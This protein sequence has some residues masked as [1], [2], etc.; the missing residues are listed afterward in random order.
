[1][2]NDENW[3]APENNEVQFSGESFRWLP[4][5]SLLD[6]APNTDIQLFN[7]FGQYRARIV[8][9]EAQ[10]IY[11]A[12][13]SLNRSRFSHA[14]EDQYDTG[15][16]SNGARAVNPF[17]NDENPIFRDTDFELRYKVRNFLLPEAP[18]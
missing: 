9:A 10:L 12:D 4:Y 18:A 7:V 3:Q 8:G 13:F 16:E 11:A 2:I 1:E 5:G 14:P 17:D 15:I 6:S